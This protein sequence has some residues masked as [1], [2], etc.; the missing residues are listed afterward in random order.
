LARRETASL[1][2]EGPAVTSAV[3]RWRAAAMIPAAAFAVHQLRYL[4]AFGPDAGDELREQGHSYLHSLVP[5]IVLLLGLAAGAFLVRVARAWR[6]GEGAEH[7]R[8]SLLALWLIASAALVAIYAGQE[9]LE[10]LFSSGHPG[11]LR[12]A[13]GDGGLWSLPA[14]LMVGAAL[15]LIVRGASAVVGLAARR[16]TARDGRAR[17]AR[18]AAR[19][20]EAVLAAPPCPLARAAAGRAPP[21]LV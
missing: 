13:F 7:P 16:R 17:P 14:A 11:G 20:P 12:G 8:R 18:G 5:W 21:L 1:D 3:R 9:L 2:A 6:T 19:P 10:G 4:L 15:A